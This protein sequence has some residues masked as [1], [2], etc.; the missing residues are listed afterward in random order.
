LL[1]KAYP[2]IAKGID[3]CLL[4]V[5]RYTGHKR[6]LFVGLERAQTAYLRNLQRFWLAAMKKRLYHKS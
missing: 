6:Q 2:L 4:S 1:K 5:P 3:C